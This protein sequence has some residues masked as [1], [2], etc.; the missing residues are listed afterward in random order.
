MVIRAF[1]VYSRP[2][3]AARRKFAAHQTVILNERRFYRE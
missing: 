3:K 2:T 1:R